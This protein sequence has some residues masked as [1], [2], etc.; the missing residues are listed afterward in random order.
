MPQEKQSGDQLQSMQGE[1]EHQLL[2]EQYKL[3]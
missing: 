2:L 3:W 1:N